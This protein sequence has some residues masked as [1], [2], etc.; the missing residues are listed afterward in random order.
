MFMNTRSSWQ[1][2]ISLEQNI[3]DTALNAWRN[4]LRVCV[5]TISWHF[6]QFYCRQLKRKQN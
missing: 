3:I 5:C 4:R 1:V 6:Q 2:W